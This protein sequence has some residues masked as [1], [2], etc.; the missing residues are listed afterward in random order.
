[1]NKQLSKAERGLKGNIFMPGDKSITHRALIFNTIAK[2]KC[3]I[4]NPSPAIDCQSTSQCLLQAGAKIEKSDESYVVEGIG[5]FGLKEPTDI[6]FAGN[7]GTTARILPA[8]LSAQPFTSFLSGDES[9]RKRPMDRI[10]DPLQRMGASI[11]GRSRNKL[12]PLCIQGKDLHGIRFEMP[13][14]SAQVKSSILLAAL[15]AEGVSSVEEPA[16]SRNHTELMLAEMGAN[17]SIADRKIIVKPGDISAIDIDIPGDVSSAAFFIVAAACINGSEVVLKNISFNPTRIKFFEAL[18]KMGVKIEIQP[19]NKFYEPASDI[20]IRYSNDLKAVTIDKN[21]PEM[22][23]ELPIIAVAA[24]RAEGRTE[25]K[26]AY[27]LRFKESDRISA[28]A[29]G[30]AKM[31]AKVEEIED[32]LIID[33]PTRLKGARVNSYG[34][35]RIAMSLSIA[36]LLAEGETVIEDSDCVNIS[37][38]G[39]YDDLGCLSGKT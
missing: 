28:L 31:G 5:R 21:I 37:Y 24:T 27:E 8:L 14:A 4:T 2:G 25:I 18:T 3:R 23:D 20:I 22:I 15:F 30:L 10:I 16:V 39:F 33:G 38:P 1:M 12:L 13:V 32:G 6:L 34:D 9:L 26:N 35:H 11:F 17:I 7:S 36:A 19:N 29:E